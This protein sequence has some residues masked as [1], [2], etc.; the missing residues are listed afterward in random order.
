MPRPHIYRRD[1][2]ALGGAT[3]LSACAPRGTLAVHPGLSVSQ[4]QSVWA[5]AIGEQHP[6]A[7]HGTTSLETTGLSR[8]VRH[9][10][11]IP[12]DREVGQ[13]S[14]P[15]ER[16]D[17]M[18]DFYVAGLEQLD[19]IDA[20]LDQVAARV[21]PGQDVTVFV[22][23][24]N[25]NYAEAVYRHAQMAHDFEDGGAHISIVWPSEASTTGYL[26]DRDSTLIARD[27][28][29]R[30][31]PRLVR[32]FPGRVVLVGHSMGAFLTMETLRQMSIGGTDITGDLGG[33]VLVSPDI[34]IDVF[35][36]QVARMA[37]LPEVTVVILSQ[38]DRALQLSS[39]LAG[40]KPRLGS[41]ADMEVLSDMDLLVVD[42]SDLPNSG[43]G[44]HLAI[45][46]SPA[47]VAF[48]RGLSSDDPV[49]R[50]RR[51]S[52]LLV[53]RVPLLIPR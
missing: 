53:V 32:R 46:T 12:Q 29:E 23:G 30:I 33:L 35:Q 24:Y 49:L 19:G 1:F 42:L 40:G 28:L 7:L 27:Y 20:M 47:A 2:L 16:I 38:R 22:H 14:W 31:L 43:Q 48:I 52:G 34:R 6:L 21:Q 37:Q 5:V 13:I 50:D 44:N 3:V 25:T 11:S 39:R 36:A 45:T 9:E 15:G 18:R 8:F 26:T 4:T 41:A 10:V 17:P 51:E